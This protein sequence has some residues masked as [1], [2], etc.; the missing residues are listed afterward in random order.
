MEIINSTETFPHSTFVATIGFFDGVHLGHRYLLQMLKDQANALGKESLVISFDKHPKTIIPTDYIPAL[1]TDNEEKIEL[2]DNFGIDAFV[3]LTFNKEMANL[4]A[5]EFLKQIIVGKLG[6]HTLYVGYNHRFGKNREEGIK[7]YIK[8]GE[9]LGL[10]IIEASLFTVENTQISSSII[11]KLINTGDMQKANL[12]L[13]YPYS[14]EGIVV[15]G[16]KLGR[17]IGYPTANLKPIN[18][19]KIIPAHGVYAVQIFLHKKSFWGMLNIGNRPTIN[20]DNK[21]TIEVHIIDFDEDIYNEKIKV[22]FFQKIRDEIKF[23]SAEELIS[24]INND[25]RFTLDL[26]QKYSIK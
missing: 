2:L 20:K 8:Y 4:T 22:S 16:S 11:R 18:S 1:L 25:K 26:S 23:N 21:E 6:V 3:E 15:E 12:F 24:E 19:N 7:E 14:M 5:Y 9:E 13:S 10:K 17:T